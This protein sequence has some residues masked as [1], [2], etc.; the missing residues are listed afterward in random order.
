MGAKWIGTWAG[1]RIRE[2]DGEPV[3]V[4]QR[5]V[6]G[7]KRLVIT[8]DVDN[9]DD[10][11]AELRLFERDPL[12]YR[13]Q[14]QVIAAKA[15]GDPGAATLDG[16]T[17]EA[18]LKHCERQGLTEDYRNDILGHYLRAW[19]NA[20]GRRDIRTVQLRELRVMLDKWRTARHH[21]IVALKSFTAWLREEDRLRRNEDPTLDLK[22]PQPIAEKSIRVK[23]YAMPEV[24]RVYAEVAS[25][26]L[27]DT[28]CLRAKTGMHDTEIARV[29]NGQAVLR[30]I[31]DPSGIFGTITFRHL[32]AG[33]VHVV[34][35]DRQ[36][37]DA[38][39]RLQTRGSPL[40]RN[41]AKVMLD[42]AAKRLGRQPL[43]P[44][45]LRHSFATWA[46]AQGRIVR[47]TEGGVPLSE[48]AAVMGHM[49]HRTTKVFY[50]G[51]EVPPM[52]I[53]PLNLRHP[54]DPAALAR[55]HAARSSSSS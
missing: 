48:V 55:S 50:E 17:L 22:V 8:L 23:G 11:R 47:P 41:A 27:R 6:G 7:G 37:F 26:V 28:L 24:E 15:A 44:G 16:D 38:A 14:R 34:S 32:K 31:N 10:A 3:W 4:I 35:V 29:A 53:L 39:Q 46:R 5:R 45:E 43:K 12:S 1:G 51:N 40:S 30:V 42:R 36:T 21:R 18:F 49:N 52:I 19:G 33:K 9:E 25:Q 13:S 20:L 2:V 54:E